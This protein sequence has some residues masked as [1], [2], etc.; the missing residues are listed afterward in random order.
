MGAGMGAR[1]DPGGPIRGRIS[2]FT[3]GMLEAPPGFEPGVEVLQT[4]ALP[5]GD[6]AS[7]GEL[8]GTRC[9]NYWPLRPR[10]RAGPRSE[11]GPRHGARSRA[12]K[13]IG[14]GNGI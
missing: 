4:S 3:E 5:L 11:D 12:R 13:K 1:R 10:Y 6:G 9:L 8:R 7:I 2:E 14:A